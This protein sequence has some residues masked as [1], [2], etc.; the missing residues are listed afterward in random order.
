MIENRPKF[1]T[2]S[3][4][5]CLLKLSGQRI[6]AM[7]SYRKLGFKFG[8]MWLFTESD[9]ANMRIRDFKRCRKPLLPSGLK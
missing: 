7:A 6:R 1:Y 2:V 3:E 8:R 4:M 9:L 5:A